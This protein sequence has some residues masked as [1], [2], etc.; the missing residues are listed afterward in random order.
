MGEET[1]TL[2]YSSGAIQGVVVL[3]FSPILFIQIGLG[4]NS[5]AQIWPPEWHTAPLFA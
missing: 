2:N 5:Y 3:Y 1:E 4:A